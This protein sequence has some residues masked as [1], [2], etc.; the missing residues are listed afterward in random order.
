MASAS[1]KTE[2]LEREDVDADSREE[3]KWRVVLYNCECHTFEQVEDVLM[4]AT[5]C[6]LS[7]ARKLAWEVHS[8]GLAVV[9]EGHKERCE[10]VADVIGETGLVV[11]VVK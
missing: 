4:R 2:V 5:R 10:A 1:A 9:Y 7:K 3:F 11:Q 8:R 6:T